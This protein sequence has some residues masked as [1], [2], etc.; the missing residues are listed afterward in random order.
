MDANDTNNTAT[1]NEA[2]SAGDA[3]SALMS[4]SAPTTAPAKETPAAPAKDTAQAPQS[5][6]DAREAAFLGISTKDSA[7]KEAQSAAAKYI[8]GEPGRDRAGRFT[9]RAIDNTDTPADAD[10]S[11]ADDTDEGGEGT[12]TD[13]AEDAT[14]QD[15]E[16]DGSLEDLAAAATK[17]DR[18]QLRDDSTRRPAGTEGGN[19]AD[20]PASSTTKAPAESKDATAS[21]DDDEKPLTKAEL[22][23]ILDAEG[24][25][26]WLKA[27][28]YNLALK[29]RAE[30]RAAEKVKNEQAT[31]QQAQQVDQERQTA[32][33]RRSLETE[34]LPALNKVIAE[35]PALRAKY[36]KPGTKLGEF[37]QA[38]T[39]AL[40]GIIHKAV[41]LVAKSEQSGEPITMRKAT[42]M[43]LAKEHVG[44]FA[45]AKQVQETRA[46]ETVKRHN[47]KTLAATGT[48]TT[49]R[50]STDPDKEKSNLA[51]GWL[52]RGRK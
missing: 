8:S 43:V 33:M 12:A 39:N 52:A 29:Q 22:D 50:A 46:E 27:K 49:R 21:E 28:E 23:E 16:D 41:E 25:G 15:D 20:Q 14:G 6:Q 18:I 34:I 37:N 36:G 45:R 13:Q 1:G 40:L 44:E 9:G 5:E 35:V 10:H 7:T 32:Q 24:R 19:A 4:Q 42:R 51:A 48:G 31:R 3:M 2:P 30:A 38:E 47:V 17:L 26:A 11:R